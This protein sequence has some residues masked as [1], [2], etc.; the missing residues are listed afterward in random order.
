[1]HSPASCT[2]PFA[3]KDAAQEGTLW[4]FFEARW[5]ASSNLRLK[6]MTLTP[7]QT[8][9]PPRRIGRDDQ[10]NLLDPQPA[11]DDSLALNRLA[12][13][14]ESFKID[15]PVKLVFRCESGAHACFVL[16]HP[17][18]QTIRNAGV[19]GLRPVRHDVDE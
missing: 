5:C 15:Q 10:R 9:V 11:F 18:Y 8:Q 1:M 16:S 17:A 12:D 4:L 7:L 14:F 19:K 3:A 13:V 2:G 6:L